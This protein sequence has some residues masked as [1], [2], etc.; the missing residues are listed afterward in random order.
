MEICAKIHVLEADIEK[1]T[2]NVTLQVFTKH[3]VEITKKTIPE[4]QNLSGD[5]ISD[6]I[7]ES[8]NVVSVKYRNGILKDVIVH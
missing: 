2:R 8:C 1:T 3:I 4:L 6:I 5:E 7:V